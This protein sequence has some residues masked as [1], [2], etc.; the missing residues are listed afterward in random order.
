MKREKRRKITR[1]RESE[2]EKTTRSQEKA[3]LRDMKRE[4]L[5]ARSITTQNSINDIT[6]AQWLTFKA[7]GEARVR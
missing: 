5:I 1:E 2:R 6:V 7:G 4:Q 3:K